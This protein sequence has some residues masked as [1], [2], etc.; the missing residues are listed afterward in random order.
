MTNN[1]QSEP[2]V[3]PVIGFIGLGNLG[4][5]MAGRLAD[6]GIPLVIWNRTRSKAESLAKSVGDKA[7]LTIAQTPADLASRSDL[8]I[9]NLFDTMAVKE[10]IAGVNGIFETDCRGKVIIDTTTN[11]F[12]EV[13]ML[14][15]LIEDAGG[16]FLEAP[17]LGSVLPASQ[18]TLT[19]LVSG[20]RRS[21]DTA[22]PTLDILAKTI[23]YLEQRM[24]ATQVKLINNLVLGSFMG[25]G[26]NRAGETT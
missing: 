7:K 16:T 13:G 11:H 10:V 26:R 8:V 6:Q 5:A 15:G 20:D 1:S 3:P 19:M 18:G 9:L 17:V 21:F 25:C 23:F 14:Y 22:K 12:S 4:S 24:V 2:A